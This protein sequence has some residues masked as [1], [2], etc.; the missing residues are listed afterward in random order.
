M[1]V[2]TPTLIATNTDLG[3]GLEAA[4][5]VPAAGEDDPHVAESRGTHDRALQLNGLR[6]RAHH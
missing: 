6:A 3:V 5:G 4:G 2:V 1:V